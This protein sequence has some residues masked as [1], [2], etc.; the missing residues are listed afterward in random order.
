[1]LHSSRE[2]MCMLT[3]AQCEYRSGYWRYWLVLQFNHMMMVFPGS[4]LTS[5]LGIKQTIDMR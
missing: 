1:M 4:E 5:G 3:E 2:D